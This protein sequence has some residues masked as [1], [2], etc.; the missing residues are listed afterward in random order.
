LLTT[1]VN[2]WLTISDETFIT[3]RQTMR[4]QSPQVLM[5]ECPLNTRNKAHVSTAF[6]LISL[7]VSV[8]TFVTTMEW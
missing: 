2:I 4:R 3:E 6:Q 8:E 5:T 7:D 1:M